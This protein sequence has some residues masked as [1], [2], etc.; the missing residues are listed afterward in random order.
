MRNSP[1]LTENSDWNIKKRDD[2]PGKT[3]S[4]RNRLFLN[5]YAEQ[6][7]RAPVNGRRLWGFLKLIFQNASDWVWL[8]GGVPKD[9]LG[10]VPLARNRPCANKYELSPD[11]DTEQRLQ[12]AN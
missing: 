3:C 10:T 5:W 2:Y 8:I 12:G 1:P 7:L 9:N 11:S 4:V 6:E